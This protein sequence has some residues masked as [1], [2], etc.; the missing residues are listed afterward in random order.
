MVP[1]YLEQLD[2]IPMTL[3][4]KADHKEL[5]KPQVPRFSAGTNYVPPKTE[6][7]RILARALAEVLRVERVSTEDHFFDDLGANSLLMARFCAVIRKH[8]GMSD[9]SMRDIYINPTIATLATHL[10]I[11]RRFRRDHARAVPRPVE[12]RLLHLRRVA[13]RVLRGLRA[14]R[15]VGARYRLSV[16]QRD[17][18]RAGALRAQR[19]VRRGSFVVLTAISILAKWLLVGRFKAQSIPIWSL[20]Y[21]RF[22][23]VKTM[24]RTRP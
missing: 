24:M 9:V 2:V 5:P 12:S 22:W 11:D 17:P 15:P 19:R 20:A 3:S 16:G 6:T 13:A 10:D 21:F 1:A 14:V 4:N 23:V 8:P 7:E 18:E